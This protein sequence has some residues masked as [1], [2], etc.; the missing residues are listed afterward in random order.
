MAV[1]KK[2]V[3]LALV[4][5]FSSIVNQNSKEDM[6]SANA[7]IAHWKAMPASVVTAEA[8]SCFGYN[9]ICKRTGQAYSR[10]TQA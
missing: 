6:E 4:E 8:E 10:C 3:I 7:I 1:T 2:S 5:A 9:A